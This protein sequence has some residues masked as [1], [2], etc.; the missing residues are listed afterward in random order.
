MGGEHVC[1]RTYHQGIW[2]GMNRCKQFAKVCKFSCADT[3]QKAASVHTR[4]R[5][6]RRIGNVLLQRAVNPSVCPIVTSARPFD[7]NRSPNMPT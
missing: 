6:I 2:E 1:R 5:R 4:T 7:E 3:L